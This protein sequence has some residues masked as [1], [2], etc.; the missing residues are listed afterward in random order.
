VAEA[1]PPDQRGGERQPEHAEQNGQALDG[2]AVDEV[3]SWVREA[4]GS[5]RAGASGQV[6]DCLGSGSGWVSLFNQ[7]TSLA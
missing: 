5:A 4:C 3:G 2:S 1:E 6:A 7:R